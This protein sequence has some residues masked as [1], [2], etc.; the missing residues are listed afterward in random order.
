[1]DSLVTAQQDLEVKFLPV[2]LTIYIIIV[3]QILYNNS[4]ITIYSLAYF[5]FLFIYFFWRESISDYFRCLSV[6][7]DRGNVLRDGIFLQTYELMPSGLLQLREEGQ[8]H[9]CRPSL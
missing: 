9:G 1:M 6:S 3:P 8:S 7:S 2:F 5:Y 4:S